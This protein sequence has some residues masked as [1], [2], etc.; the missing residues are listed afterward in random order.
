MPITPKKIVSSGAYVPKQ[1]EGL[2]NHITYHRDKGM[3]KTRLAAQHLV[4]VPHRSP[5][6]PP[7]NVPATVIGGTNSIRNGDAQR[8]DVVRH[9]TIRHVHVVLILLSHLVTNGGGGAFFWS[10]LNE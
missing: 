4:P 6:D 10:M 8:T 2:V 3:K 5:Q 1:P 9:Y 7:Q